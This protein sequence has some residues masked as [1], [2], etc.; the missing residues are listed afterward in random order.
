MYKGS[1]TLPTHTGSKPAAT[2]SVW[3]RL[4]SLAHIVI[5]K[6]FV[7]HWTLKYD[8]GLLFKDQQ[9]I[10]QHCTLIPEY[11]LVGTGWDLYFPIEHKPW[12]GR[13][14]TCHTAWACAPQPDIYSHVCC[15]LGSWKHLILGP[16]IHRSGEYSRYSW[17]NQGRISGVLGA[18]GST[19]RATEEREAGLGGGDPKY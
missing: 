16:D 8:V 7:L 11:W 2:G 13:V 15:W 6:N 1:N 10:W 9:N 12:G 18:F 3:P 5:F 19:A 17:G 4:L 14:P